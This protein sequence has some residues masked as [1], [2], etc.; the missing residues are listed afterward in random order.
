MTAWE[1]CIKRVFE[2]LRVFFRVRSQLGVMDKLSKHLLQPVVVL[3]FLGEETQSQSH[4]LV[5]TASLA[6]TAA[7]AWNAGLASQVCMIPSSI[8]IVGVRRV[9]RPFAWL[10]VLRMVGQ[11]IANEMVLSWL[12]DGQCHASTSLTRYSCS[13]LVDFSCVP[14][15]CCF[16]LN[17]FKISIVA[18]PD[19]SS[20]FGWKSFTLIK[21]PE[22]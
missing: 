12:N 18:L 8:G 20:T 1:Q 3:A 22:F 10:V 19:L 14:V 13:S 4:S 7:E 6:T 15:A 2:V 16:L 11:V 17:S 21:D 9:V 5:G